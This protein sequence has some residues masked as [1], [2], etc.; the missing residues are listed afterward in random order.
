[1]AETKFTPMFPFFFF[2]I[3]VVTEFVTILLLFYGFFLGGGDGP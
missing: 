2:S 1:M 3:K